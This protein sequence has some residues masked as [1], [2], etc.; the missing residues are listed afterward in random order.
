MHMCTHTHLH[1]AIPYYVLCKQSPVAMSAET[2]SLA[3]N[4]EN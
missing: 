2:G 3:Q 4:N 1:R